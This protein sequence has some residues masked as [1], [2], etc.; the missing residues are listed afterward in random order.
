MIKIEINEI[1]LFVKPGISILEATRLLG[2]IVP[3][4]CYH[5]TLSVAG[6][7][8][9][10]LV[11]VLNAKGPVA[12]CAI[13]VDEGIK[14]FTNTPLVKKARENVLELLL[15][16][17]PLDC[18]ICD[19]G[20]ECDL[21]DQAK[22][23]GSDFSRFFFKKRSTEKKNF[24]LLIKAIMTRCIHCTRCVRYSTE[25]AGVETLG[26]LNRG[27]NSEIGNYFKQVLNSEIS[28]NVIDL[29]P[30]GALTAKSY[31]FK[32]RPWELKLVESID[33]SDTLGSN[34]LINI[35]DN[36]IVRILPKNNFNINDSIITD[37]ARFSFD[38]LNYNRIIKIIKKNQET[39]T[40]NTISD[41]NVVLNNLN[42]SLIK[43]TLILINNEIDVESIELLKLL[44]FKNKKN[45][46]LRT[47]QTTN[48]TNYLINW[49]SCKIK[50]INKVSSLCLLLCTNPKIESAIINSKLRIK[51]LNES[52]NIIGLS[53]YYNSNFKF[54]FINLSLKF[55]KIFFE[56]KK[57]LLSTL[58]IKSINPIIC[59]GDLTI[60]RN[61]KVD[62]LKNLITNIN[63]LQTSSSILT[64]LNIKS[65]STNDFKNISSL[66]LVDLNDTNF[67][68]K[69]LVSLKNLNTQVFWFNNFGSYLA[70]KAYLII[71]TY[72]NFEESKI[73]IN[74]EER[75]QQ[76]TKSINSN[77]TTRS[78][79]AI[80]KTIINKKNENNLN[81][82]QFNKEIIENPELF[83]NLKIIFSKKL[84]KNNN[85][86]IKKINSYPFKLLTNNF[87]NTDKISKNSKIM[88]N[89]SNEYKNLFLN[90]SH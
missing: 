74:S 21:Q 53:N 86:N 1:P 71:P 49:N 83:N 52:F 81:H 55:I 68:Y 35:K 70:N 48:N 6:N 62:N 9:M 72:S 73:F 87:Y 3:R 75:P 59:T 22:I 26:V 37:K 5:E 57:K 27:V 16:N 13:L 54:K 25:I 84:L 29:C 45:F 20:G 66:W 40:F 12:S 7:C 44:A 34:I 65:L 28:G 32:A 51:F 24:G 43:K 8:R 60:I 30:V 10:C 63:I 89:C 90:F 39:N 18:P 38:G 50:D 14:I 46:I 82:F 77:T 42:S 79:S 11:E 67:L 78:F 58:F 69:K 4:F 23:Y 2:I 41:W 19:Q 17:H 56:S 47:L 85:L 80:I 36:K 33:T 76:T 88:L 61:L 31:M 64:K 15:V